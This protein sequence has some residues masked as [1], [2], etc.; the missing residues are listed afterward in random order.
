MI[1]LLLL[2]LSALTPILSYFFCKEISYRFYF[3]KKAFSDK[4]FWE[5]KLSDEELEEIANNYS[6][7]FA[8][9]GTWIVSFVC[10]PF[11]VYLCYLNYIDDF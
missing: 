8:K 1:Y 5:R 10:I 4:W 9:I 2:L 6:K 3:K 11:F 7:L